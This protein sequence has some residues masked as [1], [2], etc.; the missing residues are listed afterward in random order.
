MNSQD[1]KQ[2]VELFEDAKIKERVFSLWERVFSASNKVLMHAKNHGFNGMSE[3][4][5]NIHE[6]MVQLQI[7][8]AVLDILITNASNLDVDYDEIRLM[9]NAKEQITRMERIAAA[10]QANNKED[11]EFAVDDLERQAPF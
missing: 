10:L 2:I 6:M 8:S 7:F 1:Q 3:P 9:L 4:K 5:P 11:F